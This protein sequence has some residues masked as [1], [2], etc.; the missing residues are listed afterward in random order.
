MRPYP[1]DEFTD[2]QLREEWR[3]YRAARKK[4]AQGGIGVVAGEGRRLEFTPGQVG[5]I[6]LE[7][8]EIGVEARRRGLDWAG[9]ASAITVEVG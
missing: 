3:Q 8:R 9:D 6:D 4:S 5:T 7:L 2:E 1:P